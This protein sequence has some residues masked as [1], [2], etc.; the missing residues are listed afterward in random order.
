MAEDVGFKLDIADPETGKTY[1][2]KVPRS[3]MYILIGKRIGDKVPGDYFGL[4]GYML[5]ITGGSDR[6]GFPMTAKFQGP[7]RRRVMLIAGEPGFRKIIIKHKNRKSKKTKP[8]KKKPRFLRKRRSV[9]G[10]TISEATYQINMVIIRK[11]STPIE[12]LIKKERSHFS[13]DSV[14]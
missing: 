12:E 4:P 7:E 13:W 9:R 5:K 8:F 10:M 2:V 11:G 14:S 6:D 1:S 3:K